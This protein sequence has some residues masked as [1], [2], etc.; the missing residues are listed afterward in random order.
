M[1]EGEFAAR[2]KPVQVG[3]SPR[4]Q[5]DDREQCEHGHQRDLAPEMTSP[6][7]KSVHL[8]ESARQL[9]TSVA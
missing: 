4:Q 6:V 8:L 2:Y 9:F 3:Y 7:D 1:P 5:P